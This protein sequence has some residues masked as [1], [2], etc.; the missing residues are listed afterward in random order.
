M[1]Y[2][3]ILLPVFLMSISVYSQQSVHT[4]SNKAMKL[5]VEGTRD[6]DFLNL[7]SAE[8]NLKAAIEEDQRFYE[9]YMVLG[10]ML[11]KQKRYSEA[12]ENYR[13]AVKIDSL[14]YKPVF[15]SLAT[16][17]MMSGDYERALV[18]Y[19]VYVRQPGMSEKNVED[20]SDNIRNC[21]FA[22]E[23]MRNPVVFNPENAGP[24]INTRDDEYWPSITAD[25]GTLIFT[26]QHS[27]QESQ[28]PSQEDFYISRFSDD[29]WQKAVSAGAPL[30]TRQN[31]GAQSLSSD[32]RYMY[33]TACDRQGA[34]GSCDIYFSYNSDG[35]WS[36]PSNIGPPVNSRSWESQPSISADGKT[37]IFSS[38][39]PGGIGG[40]DIWIT[41]KNENG[42]WT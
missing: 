35:K 19:K 7:S 40:K 25:G 1:K 22:I 30:N 23:A 32:G 37:L 12:A 4:S 39:R 38:S 9:A 18:H 14:F 34:M 29:A 2:S 10:E 5:Y 8:R 6:Y 36:Q 26:R 33:F 24:G 28:G 13:A 31:E 15:Y 17:E 11:S 21:E 16:A 42:T 3:F 41:R 20:A 27:L